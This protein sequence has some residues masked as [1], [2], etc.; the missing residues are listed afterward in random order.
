MVDNDI[1]K[2]TKQQLTKNIHQSFLWKTRQKP[3]FTTW[4]ARNQNV[5]VNSTNLTN[6]KKKNKLHIWPR[7]KE[8]IRM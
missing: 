3:G 4:T 2:F 7:L 5:K 1:F 6:L 8:F